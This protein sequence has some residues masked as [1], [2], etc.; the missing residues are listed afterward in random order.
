MTNDTTHRDECTTT[1]HNHTIQT[2]RTTQ[3]RSQL[4]PEHTV[5]EP[6]ILY[7]GFG[8]NLLPSILTNKK[9]NVLFSQPAFIP[10]IKL[11]FN[12]ATKSIVEPSYANLS[13]LTKTQ[14]DTEYSKLQHIL[15]TTHNDPTKLAQ[16]VQT[17]DKSQLCC[18]THGVIHEL[19]QTDMSRMDLLEGNGQAYKRESFDCITYA[20]RHVRVFAYICYDNE[21][22]PNPTNDTPPSTVP[23]KINDLI[24]LRDVPPSHRYLRVLINGAKHYKLNHSYIQWLMNHPYTPLP[25]CK[26]SEKHQK[27]IES[28]AITQAEMKQHGW[29]DSYDT[30]P[31]DQEPNYNPPLWTS[32][33][34]IVFDI[35]NI[36][37]PRTYKKM[38]SGNDSTYFSAG[39]VAAED[40]DDNV[41]HTDNDDDSQVYRQINTDI[42]NTI[43]ADTSKPEADKPPSNVTRSNINNNNKPTRDIHAI[44]QTIDQLQQI[45]KNYI[46][47]VIVDY[48]H[49]GCEIQGHLDDWKQYNF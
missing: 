1:T 42:N 9:I 5:P 12:L 28:R 49:Q 2:N 8:S 27:Q 46:N 21:S 11:K 43:T 41:V 3:Y 18:G 37:F 29:N 26:I 44:P 30:V 24:E 33:K 36:R 7:F 48:I 23:V 20:G 35:S 32:L 13:H 34:G 14:Y 15:S 47:A 45:H 4:Y 10:C 17:Y 38:L 40:D 16:I 6:T 19:L 39:R 31:A 22:N 25:D